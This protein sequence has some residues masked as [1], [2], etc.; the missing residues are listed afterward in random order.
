MSLEDNARDISR[1]TMAVA[2]F[3]AAIEEIVAVAPYIA[4]WGDGNCGYIINEL[5][6]ALREEGHFSFYSES[7]KGKRRSLG[8]VVRR[9]VHERDA[10]RCVSCGSFENLTIDHI[11]PLAKGGSNEEENLQTM[12]RQCNMVKGDRL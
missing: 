4:R 8:R 2:R 9:K 6:N 1:E 7:S 5:L 10:Y 3:R 12:C 11:V